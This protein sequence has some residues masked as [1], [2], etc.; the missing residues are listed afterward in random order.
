MDIKPHIA[1]IFRPSGF[2]YDVYSLRSDQTPDER[3]LQLISG[4]AR[5]ASA[6]NAIEIDRI[7]DGTHFGSV[8]AISGLEGLLFGAA[9]KN[10]SVRKLKKTS[11]NE[12]NKARCRLMDVSTTMDMKHNPF[13]CDLRN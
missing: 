5:R 9:Q 1:G 11:Q 6:I 7:V 13:A 8:C 10:D 4:M 2:Q 3:D 12:S